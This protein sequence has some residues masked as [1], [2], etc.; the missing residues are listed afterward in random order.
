MSS[1]LYASRMSPCISKEE[2]PRILGIPPGSVASLLRMAAH[3][4]TPLLKRIVPI[5]CGRE[6][7]WHVERD[8]FDRFRSAHVTLAD[9][10]R[11]HSLAPD[12]LRRQL[13]RRGIRSVLHGSM[14][15]CGIYRLADL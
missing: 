7:H 6:A 5:I 4:G 9:L 11:Q 1:V 15:D 13:C 14:R 12:A 3:D 10:A 8:S 2:A